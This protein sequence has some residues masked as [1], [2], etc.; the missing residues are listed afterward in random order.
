MMSS[1]NYFKINEYAQRY[2]KTVCESFFAK[3][4]RILGNQIIELC[5]EKQ[6]NFFVI[7][8]LFL[9][10]QEENANIKS[11]YFDYET[12]EVKKVLTEL[13]NLLSKNISIQRDTFE[14]LL[15]EA[16]E[17]TLLWFLS[18]TDFFERIVGKQESV[19]L[20]ELLAATSKY[21]RINKTFF[22]EIAKQLVHTF[23]TEAATNK[24]LAQVQVHCE[25][26]YTPDLEQL[27]RGLAQNLPLKADDF[28]LNDDSLVFDEEP[29]LDTNSFDINELKFGIDEL[30]EDAAKTEEKPAPSPKIEEVAPV[31]K[32]EKRH[33]V[34]ERDPQ[35]PS[36]KD[37]VPLNLK[38]A[39]IKELF[40]NDNDEFNKAVDMIDQ[41]SDYHKAIMLIKEKYFRRYGWDLEKDEVK[42]FYELVSRKFY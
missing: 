32:P 41:C 16:V 21:V 4:E 1:L 5:T 12:P 29:M 11:P 34:Y 2:A 31:S 14:A 19:N 28:L 18:P 23:G 39:F 37:L 10:W 42:E 9:K 38:Y 13:L 33:I 24:V 27:T 35:S 17:Q 3:H 25:Q 8:I 40:A 26:S 7:K 22:D 6:V 15:S 30:L 36:M 20:K